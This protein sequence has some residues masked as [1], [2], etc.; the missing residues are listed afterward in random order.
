MRARDY[1]RLRPR[2]N[3][4]PT[5]TWRVPRDRVIRPTRKRS[6]SRS[7]PSDR[8]SPVRPRRVRRPARTPKLGIHVA[9]A[10]DA[11]RWC[12]SMH[13]NLVRPWHARAAPVRADPRARYASVRRAASASD[14][15]ACARIDRTRRALRPPVDSTA[16][17]GRVTVR[18]RAAADSATVGPGRRE[19]IAA[20]ARR[21]RSLEC[22]RDRVSR[23]RRDRVAPPVFRSTPS[24][25]ANFRT[26]RSRDS[27]D[28]RMAGRPRRK[29][30]R[31]P[32]HR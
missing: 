22:R 19:S 20:P 27:A 30:Q 29:A 5:T 31:K 3:P 11:A 6:R 26:H 21:I 1:G 28:T 12:A 4:P 16:D 13:P 2:S 15:R 32:R 8:Q 24:S 25:R 23:D 17:R 7:N 18:P 14:S 10:A 9:R